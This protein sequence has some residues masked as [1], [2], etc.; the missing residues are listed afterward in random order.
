MD[1]NEIAQK[2]ISVNQSY[3]N[4]IETI[5]TLNYHAALIDSKQKFIADE[6]MFSS[7]DL[8]YLQKLEDDFSRKQNQLVEENEELFYGVDSDDYK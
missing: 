7:F 6:L 5:N 1:Y 2:I 8:N 4:Y 3:G